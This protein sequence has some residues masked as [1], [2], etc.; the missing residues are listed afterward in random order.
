[1]FFKKNKEKLSVELVDM[2]V[3]TSEV[4]NIKNS[5]VVYIN[6][7]GK[8]KE[9]Y[10]E[11]EDLKNS[12]L[13]QIRLNDIPLI[14]INTD[15]Y[16]STIECLLATG[17]G[18][19]NANCKE[20]LEIQEKINSDFISLEDSIE[21]ITPLLKLLNNGF[22]MVADVEC[23]PTDGNGNFFWNVPN[24]LVLNPAT[25][26]K[27]LR[28][29][30]FTYIGRQPVYLYPTQTTDAYNS[31]R[32]DYYI[33]KFKKMSDNEPRAIV[34]NCGE[35]INFIIDGH[36][37][38]CAAALLGKPLKCIL[39]KK[40]G[41]FMESEK[42]KWVD[43]LYFFSLYEKATSKNIPKKYLP[44]KK[45]EMKIEKLNEIKLEDG[46]VNKRKWENKYLDSVKNFPSLEKYVNIVNASINFE[47]KI[48]DE[49]IKK[50]VN[51]FDENS[52]E[53]MKK[54]IYILMYTESLEKLQKIV[55]KYAKNSLNHKIDKD[56]KLMI[57]NIL[58]QMKNNS[59]VEQIFIDYI[60]YNE[61]RDD[62]VL[63]LINSYWK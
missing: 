29:D 41:Y 56:L 31:E 19:E 61:D 33:E 45:N 38:A 15:Y 55:I 52:Q 13:V 53:M 47:F 12:Y 10:K 18:I 54:I 17:Y 39:I 20:I 35:F 30:D 37:K 27:C 58:F 48:T 14:Q 2:A 9:V 21:T 63:E 4:I 32:V 16:I 49:L 42:G 1:M 11:V 24:D 36:H 25:A 59:E 46:Q 7:A 34:Y 6:G 23:Y 50:Y 57:Y 22:Y 5:K 43:K 8:L 28:D 3:D 51:I 60:V 62:P 40:A 44:F 26:M